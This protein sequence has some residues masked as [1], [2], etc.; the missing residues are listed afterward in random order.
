MVKGKRDYVKVY[1]SAQQD[2]HK[3]MNSELF[4]ITGHFSIMEALTS[5]TRNPITEQMSLF[6]NAAQ[7]HS[8]SPTRIKKNLHFFPLLMH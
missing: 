3:N 5:F 6:G 2:F 4:F 7:F 8:F 1:L